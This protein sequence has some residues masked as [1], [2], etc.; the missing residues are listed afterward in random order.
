MQNCNSPPTERY[1]K[2]RFARVLLVLSLQEVF[3]RVAVY[4]YFV[5]R[6]RERRKR[7]ARLVLAVRL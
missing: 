1:E 4:K 2:R 5:L 3:R 6:Q 7:H